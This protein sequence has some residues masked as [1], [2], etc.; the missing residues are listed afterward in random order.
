[1][2]TLARLEFRVPD[3]AGNAISGASVEIRRQGA[4]VSGTQAG[5]PYTV[6]HVNGIVASDVVALN[7]GS[8]TRTVSAITATTVTTSGGDLG[9][10]VDDDRITIATALPT[11]YEDAE[12]VTTKEN[13][14]TTDATGRAWCYV[15]GGLYDVKVSGGGATTALHVDQVALGGTNTLINL[16]PSGTSVAHIMDTLRDLAA[17]DTML[18]VR[19]AGANI[20][21][22]MGDGEIIAG[23][24]GATHAL[25]GNTTITGTLT[26][27]GALTVQADGAAVT[28]AVTATTTVTGGTGVTATTGGLT[29]TTGNVTATAGDIIATAGALLAVAS[30]VRSRRFKGEFGTALTSADIALSAGW[31]AT[32]APTFLYSN[33]FDCRGIM[34]ITST[35]AGQAANPTVTLTFKNGSFSGGASAVCQRGIGGGAGFGGD[36]PTIPFMMVSSTTTAFIMSFRGT[37]VAGESYDVWYMVMA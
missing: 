29:A 15:T 33:P 30:E 1:M 25:T 11:L 8:T 34:R 9:A 26:S 3:T 2:A 10:V 37:P 17:G 24:A 7:T 32:A 35:G 16:Y 14:L 22:I 6:D 12:S 5:S 19:S 28:G 18:A 23:E 4:Q 21:R 13:P 27:S 20:F 36:Q 31:G